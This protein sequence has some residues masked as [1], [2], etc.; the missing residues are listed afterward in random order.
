MDCSLVAD[1]SVRLTED[2]RSE[3]CRFTITICP[4]IFTFSPSLLQLGSMHQASDLFAR[5]IS[6]LNIY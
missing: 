5:F 4:E 1:T 6:Y 2:D 3:A